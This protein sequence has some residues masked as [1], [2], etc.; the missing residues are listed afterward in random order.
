MTGIHKNNVTSRCSANLSIAKRSKDACFS[1]QSVEWYTPAHIVHSVQKLLGTIDIDPCSNSTIN[2]TIPAR[3]LYT[4]VENGLRQTWKG[5]VYMNPPYG[6]EIREWVEKLHE[7]YQ[8][9]NTK[10][11]IALLPARTDTKW[12]RILRKYPRCFIHGRLKFGNAKN[13]APF[14]S[15]VVYLG[16]QQEKFRQVF[17]E[18]GD[19]YVFR[20]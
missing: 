1:S 8:A 17:S 19:V 7:E 11:A 20:N 12:F 18:L 3:Q 5:R 13:S 16:V 15:V 14:P 6:R 10:E 9:H 4:K 2:P